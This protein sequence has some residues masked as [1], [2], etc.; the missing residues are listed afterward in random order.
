MRPLPSRRPR[1]AYESTIRSQFETNF[2][3]NRSSTE[4]TRHNVEFFQETIT[5]FMSWARALTA[6]L[7]IAALG[8]M[9]P[10]GAPSASGASNAPSY[11]SDVAS[12][13]TIIA[14]P[15]PKNDSFNTLSAALLRLPGELSVLARDRAKLIAATPLAPSALAQDVLRSA[16]VEVAVE[17]AALNNAA[18]QELTAALLSSGTSTVMSLAKQFIA[19]SNAAASANA[20]LRVER[21]IAPSV[22]S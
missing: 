4:K 13:S 3:I 17:S 1:A 10:H 6:V 12:V 2:F 7:G 11:C 22:C 8:T 9:L 15:L 18:N 20:Y 16:T 19:A 5:V 14:P 21:M